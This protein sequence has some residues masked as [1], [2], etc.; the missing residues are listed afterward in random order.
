[1]TAPRESCVRK[2]VRKPLLSLLFWTG[3]RHVHLEGLEQAT[4]FVHVT[5]E[6][7]NTWVSLELAKKVESAAEEIVRSCIMD[8]V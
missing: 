4:L 3:Y 6:D 7:Y 5:M 8:M 2:L 1:M